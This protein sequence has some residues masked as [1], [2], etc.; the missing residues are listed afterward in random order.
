MAKVQA[1]R[2]VMEDRRWVASKVNRATYGDDPQVQIA[3]QMNVTLP[4]AKL[5]SLRERLAGARQL[6][7]KAKSEPE[8]A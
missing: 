6:V 4:P 2:I 7:D 1:H 8:S 5:E 3:N